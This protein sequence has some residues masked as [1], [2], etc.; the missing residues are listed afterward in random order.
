M[1]KRTA[2]RS[3]AA[4]LAFAGINLVAFVGLVLT[5]AS[6]ARDA[7]EGLPARIE[8]PAGARRSHF[9]REMV[10]ADAKV[11]VTV[12]LVA[13]RAVSAAA[14]LAGALVLALAFWFRAD[15]G[16]GAQRFADRIRGG[17]RVEGG[18]AAA[19]A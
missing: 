13:A 5:P 16:A 19:P 12:V 10:A 8:L 4:G 11:P 2:N 17:P 18:G 9:S 7:Y 3:P 15:L 14:W 6:P 1:C